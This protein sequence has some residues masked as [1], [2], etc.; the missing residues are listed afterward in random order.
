M[1]CCSMWEVVYLYTLGKRKENVD[2]KKKKD[3]GMAE[4]IY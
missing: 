2:I 3:G 1:I 4:A